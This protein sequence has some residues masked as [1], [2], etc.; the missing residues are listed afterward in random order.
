MR[1][2]VASLHDY[3]CVDC[4]MDGMDAGERRDLLLLPAQGG[5]GRGARP[6]RRPA[7]GRAVEEK[8][9]PYSGKEGRKHRPSGR[10]ATVG[11][12]RTRTTRAHGGACG[13]DGGPAAAEERAACL[14]HPS[15]RAELLLERALSEPSVIRIARVSDS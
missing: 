3:W 12:V 8:Q 5:Q 2:E 14:M 13:E 10:A 9:A 6:R 7:H 11:P 1:T 4:D 15:D